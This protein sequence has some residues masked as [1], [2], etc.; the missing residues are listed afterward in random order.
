VARRAD[1]QTGSRPA[2]GRTRALSLFSLAS[3]LVLSAGGARADSDRLVV[4]THDAALA[5]ALSVAVS[6]RGLSVVELPEPLSNVADAPAARRTVAVPGTVA[7]VWLCDDEVG[8]HALCFCD[9]DG[10]LFVKPVTVTSP[11]APPDAA[12][13]ALSVK[14]LL[15]APPAPHARAAPPMRPIEPPPRLAP[16]Q[17]ST[18]RPALPA[19][20]LG[21]TVGARLQSSA[22]QHVGARLGLEGVF[23]PDIFGRALGL[24]LGLGAGTAL[25]AGGPTPATGARRTVND[26]AL[27]LSA[28]GRLRFQNLWLELDL[29]PSAHV[30]SVET[31]PSAPRRTDLSLDARAGAVM[32]LGRTLVGIR[33]GGFAMLTSATTV[34]SGATPVELPRWN[35]EALLTFGVALR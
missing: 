22:S 15:G 16:A 32:P 26:L 17:Q 33:A 30:L 6:P 27:G 10:R 7:V 1:I 11:L 28:R 35:G 18:A 4:G 14:M 23:A 2:F 21:L 29:G 19:L 3:S 8:A 24:G 13:V 9:R 20:V 12:A 5:S 31:G 34:P 25:A